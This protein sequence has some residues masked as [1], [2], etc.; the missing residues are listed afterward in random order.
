LLLY[1]ALLTDM[2]LTFYCLMFILHTNFK[3]SGAHL[4]P[5]F[6]CEKGGNHC[7]VALVRWGPSG[8]TAKGIMNEGDTE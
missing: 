1:W 5:H 7:T 8:I 6:T 4:R 2:L 3:F